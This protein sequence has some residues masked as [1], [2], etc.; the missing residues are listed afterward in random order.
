MSLL[1]G[2]LAAVNLVACYVLKEKSWMRYAIFL[3][4]AMV[5]GSLG[6]FL[7][8]GVFHITSDALINGI[9]G[10]G[11][12]HVFY[13]IALRNVSPLLLRPTLSSKDNYGSPR[14]L[15]GNLAIWLGVVAAG[16]M[17][18][19]AT[20]F[21]PA[22]IVL[23]IGALGYGV[24]LLTVLAFAITKWFEKYSVSFRLSLALGFLLFFLSDWTIAVRAFR[25]PLFLN[26]LFVGV[27]YIIGQL[28]IQV[29]PILIRR[30]R[31]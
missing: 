26:N 22:D 9:L 6:D 25:N 8:A 16:V 11:I 13:V 10:F 12:G 15:L 2:V 1:L 24:L 5:F 4:V 19:F 27:T 21:D 18:F 23:S 28:L 7:L 14:L 3:F 29:T 17:L 31:T 20:V 30:S